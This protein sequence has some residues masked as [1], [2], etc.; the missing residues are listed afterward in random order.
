[1]CSVTANLPREDVARPCRQLEPCGRCRAHTP[2]AGS[3]A[4][5]ETVV[6]LTE[7]CT[8][9]TKADRS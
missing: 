2:Q 8:N 4:S 5:S 3:M 6:V 9:R 1:M 7:T